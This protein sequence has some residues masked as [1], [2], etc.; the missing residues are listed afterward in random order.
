[1]TIGEAEAQLAS[2][3]MQTNAALFMRHVQAFLFMDD[4]FR[5][6]EFSRKQHTPV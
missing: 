4:Y 1:V 6:G 2:P 3:S 5:F